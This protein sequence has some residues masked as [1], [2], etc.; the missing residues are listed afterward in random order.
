MDC[1]SSRLTAIAS[2]PGCTAGAVACAVRAAA[3]RTGVYYRAPAAALYP[4]AEQVQMKMTCATRASRAKDWFS[5]P[6]LFAL[7]GASAALLAVVT[8]LHCNKRSFQW[9]LGHSWQ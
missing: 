1:A 4:C 6:L 2:V 9:S 8:A 3:E 7:L 5:E